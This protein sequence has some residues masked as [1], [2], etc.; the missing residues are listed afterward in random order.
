[1]NIDVL[2]PEAEEI[3]ASISRAFIFTEAQPRWIWRGKYS[4]GISE[5]EGIRFLSQLK[6]GAGGTDV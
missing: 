5:A 3:P 4:A 1:M 6:T 2:Y